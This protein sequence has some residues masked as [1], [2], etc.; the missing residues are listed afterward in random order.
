MKLS[1]V[2]YMQRV[3]Y[4]SHPPWH[5]ST[6]NLGPSLALRTKEKRLLELNP[7][8]QY[9]WGRKYTR[10][11]ADFVSGQLRFH[12]HYWYPDVMNTIV[13]NNF[14]EIHIIVKDGII[15]NILDVPYDYYFS[16]TK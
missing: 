10:R 11:L 14:G 16:N 3:R 6:K 12:T 5:T 2:S 7:T 13:R 15:I 4:N 1:K 8:M 9:I